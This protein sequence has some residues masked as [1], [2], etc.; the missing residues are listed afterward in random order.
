MRW[1]LQRGSVGCAR[2]RVS[3]IPQIRGHTAAQSRCGYR[4]D[5]VLT[6]SRNTE[7]DHRIGKDGNVL[8]GRVTASEIGGADQFNRIV[9]NPRKGIG[10]RC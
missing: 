6:G 9:S 2:T 7:I 8:Y 1:V 4:E 3:E 10:Q 5:R